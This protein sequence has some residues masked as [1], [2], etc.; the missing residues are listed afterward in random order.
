MTAGPG[1]V[2]EGSWQQALKVQWKQAQ[3]KPLQTLPQGGLGK[4]MTVGLGPSA[5][6]MG[7]LCRSPCIL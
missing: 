2:R 1:P 6:K 3:K 4:H 7:V 5:L